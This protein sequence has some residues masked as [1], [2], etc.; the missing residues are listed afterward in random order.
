MLAVTVR[1]MKSLTEE[2]TL[3]TKKMERVTLVVKGL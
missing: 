3:Q 2:D 1:N